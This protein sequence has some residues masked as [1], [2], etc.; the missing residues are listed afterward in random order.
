[1]TEEIKHRVHPNGSQEWRLNGLKHRLDGP[2][3]IDSD[4]YQKWYQNGL[5]HRVDGPAVIWADGTEFWLQNGK[6][7]RLDGPAIIDADGGQTWYVNDIDVTEQIKEIIEDFS[8]N[9]D[10]NQWTDAEKVLVQ[11]AIR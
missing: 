3:F 5:C 7:H 11:L 8:I 1:M 6:F 2:A 4:G 9:S 10:Y